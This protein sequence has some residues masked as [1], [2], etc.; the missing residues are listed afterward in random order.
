MNDLTPQ[1]FLAAIA[2]EIDVLSCFQKIT[3]WLPDDFQKQLLTI[4][5]EEP[6]IACLAGRG[7]GK[8]LTIAC[9]AVYHA[10][11]TPD[12][13]VLCLSAS[14]KQCLELF[15]TIKIAHSKLPLAHMITRETAQIL[16]LANGARIIC[17]SASESSSRGWR[18]T[19]ILAD[20]AA[21]IDDE[22]FTSLIPSLVAK[23]QLIL[24]TTP[25]GA[26]GFFYEIYTEG[27]AFNIIQK[28]T[29]LP[30]MREVVERDMKA[31]SEQQFRAEHLCSFQGSADNAFFSYGLIQDAFANDIKPANIHGIW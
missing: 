2:G 3:G 23:G 14:I 1:T 17:V 8:S 7:S 24:V 15:R 26:R 4:G 30:R 22:I 16:Q 19:L 18:A 31:L 11:T 12:A 29:D 28:S 6:I 25:N 10:N 13:V 9:R 20:E 27:R 21:R 5:P